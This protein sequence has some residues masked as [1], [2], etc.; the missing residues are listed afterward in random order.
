[1][2]S[3][4]VVRKLDELGRM[5]LLKELRRTLGIQ[6]GDGVEVFVDAD[7]IV[8]RKYEPGCVLQG[9]GWTAGVSWED[10]VWEMSKGVWGCGGC[11]EEVRKEGARREAG[12][13]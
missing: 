6:D 12:V 4:G 9:G 8:L 2:R 11:W 1:M 13:L 10:G 7:R 5:V 3:T